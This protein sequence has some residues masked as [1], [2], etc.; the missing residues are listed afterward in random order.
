MSFVNRNVRTSTAIIGCPHN[1]TSNHKEVKKQTRLT[2]RLQICHA[3][4]IFWLFQLRVRAKINSQILS[5]EAPAGQG[6]KAQES[7]A[8]DSELS[9]RRQVGFIGT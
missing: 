2:F 6:A 3:Y 1:H 8:A 4:L 9:Q 7:A 5:V